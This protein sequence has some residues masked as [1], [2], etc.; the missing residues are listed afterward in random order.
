MD[1]PVIEAI[2]A[3]RHLLANAAPA[4]LI[5]E[6]YKVLRSGSAEATFRLLA[7]HGLLET[8]T[9]ELHRGAATDALWQALAELDRYRQRFDTVPTALTNP[10]LLGTL[11]VPLGLMPRRSAAALEN[12]G[13]EHDEES[14]GDA[15]S[16]VEPR[17]RGAEFWRRRRER[18]GPKEPPLHIGMLPVARRDTERLRQMLAVQRRLMDLES[19]PRAKRALMHRGPFQEA[20]VWLEIHGR[21]PEALEHWRGFIEATTSW[22]APESTDSAIPDG[23]PRPR[24]RRRRGRGRGKRMET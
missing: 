18:R 11:L 9:P 15:G 12:D 10:I 22:V 2:R 20:L 19:T 4:R 23:R 13:A 17:R 14:D 8:I 24:R 1:R 16:R 3:Y 6:Y 5:E 21:S 7:T